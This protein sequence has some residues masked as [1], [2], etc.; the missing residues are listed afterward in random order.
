[1][2]ITILATMSMSHLVYQ[3]L[4]EG[5]RKIIKDRSG[6]IAM[7]FEEALDSNLRVCLVNK[8]NKAVIVNKSLKAVLESNGYNVPYEIQW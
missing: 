1:M 2:D 7:E 3:E 6:N 5:G 4:P 8:R